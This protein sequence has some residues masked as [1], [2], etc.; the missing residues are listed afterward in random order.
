MNPDPHLEHVFRAGRS[1]EGERIV[2]AD[3][4]GNLEAEIRARTKSAA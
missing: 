1:E 4:A 3:F 2:Y